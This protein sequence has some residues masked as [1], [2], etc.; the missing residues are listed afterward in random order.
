LLD[1][2]EHANLLVYPLVYKN[3]NKLE[4]ICL[5]DALSKKSVEITEI[6][7]GGSVPELYL[8][9][10]SED[11]VLLLDGEELIGAKQNR[12]LNTTI[13]VEKNVKT[14]IPVSCVEAGRWG[15]TS[16]NFSSSNRMSPSSLKM[17]KSTS[18]SRSLSMSAGI[19]YRSDQ[20]EVWNEVDRIS[21]SAR[22][23]SPSSA[24]SDVYDKRSSEIEKYLTDIKVIDG[25]NGM[26]V[27]INGKV[28]GL[29]YVSNVA[30]FPKLFAKLVR[31]YAMD[32][33]LDVREVKSNGFEEASRQF[34]AKIGTGS[35]EVFKSVGLGNDHRLTSTE[36]V[37]SALIFE[38]EVVHLSALNKIDYSGRTSNSEN[39][40]SSFIRRLSR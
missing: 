4:Y 14:K 13:L 22:V 25:Q 27:L 3:G 34:I 31:G 11:R 40:S 12:I 10:N 38:D 21:S 24:M 23:S 35:E 16:Q 7:E 6:N 1:K 39:Q 33:I 18:V 5:D 37:G 26:V 8:S 2:Q 29:E 15:Y 36:F 19:S 32:A 30:A 9:N 28:V 20:G 17:S